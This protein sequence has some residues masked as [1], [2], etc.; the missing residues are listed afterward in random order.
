MTIADLIS[1]VDHKKPT[2][3]LTQGEMPRI[4]AEIQDAL[5]TDGTVFQRGGQLVHLTR[6]PK[7]GA[8]DGIRRS[9]GALVISPV[10]ARWL[11]IRMATCARFVRHAA[12]TG[13]EVVKDPPFECAQMLA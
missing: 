8:K 1:L 10:S 2:I 3:V 7:A 11:Q 9:Q 4:L 5:I 13:H 6:I 12:K